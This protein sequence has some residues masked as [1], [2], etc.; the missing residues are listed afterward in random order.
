M[1]NNPSLQHANESIDNDLNLCNVYLSIEFQLFELQ[2]SGMRCIA[3]SVKLLSQI[4]AQRNYL[5][6]CNNF[7]EAQPNLYHF[8]LLY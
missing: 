7:C 1:N 4:L 6:F 3:V 5:S 8:I 2:Q